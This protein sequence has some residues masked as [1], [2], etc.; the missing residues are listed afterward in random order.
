MH[1]LRPADQPGSDHAKIEGRPVGGEGRD[2]LSGRLPGTEAIIFGNLADSTSA[3]A[4]A[5]TSPRNYALLAEL[6][7][8][9]APTY[10]A[11]LSNPSEEMSQR[12]RLHR[13]RVM[14][15]HD[16]SSGEHDH[17]LPIGPGL[18][19]GSVT[20]K[21]SSLVLVRPYDWR[22]ILGIA[23]GFALTMMLFVAVTYLLL[24]GVG[25]WGINVPVMWGF[26]IVNFVWWIGIGHAGT[27]ISAILLLLKQDWR[28]SINR[29]P[30]H[31]ALRG[32]VCRSLP[33]APSG[34][35]LGLL[36]VAP[37]PQ[38][39]GFMASVAKS[40]DLGR[41][42]GLNLRHGLAPLLVRGTSA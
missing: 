15:T 22:W 17:G 8:R 42:R 21:I 9:S 32:R 10:L 39:D 13:E 1:V 33:P 4:R 16:H 5:K 27:L 3:V 29:L 30:S 6:N 14:T 2:R 18:T 40:F 41:F 19:Y 26:A 35:A 24:K 12:T 31:D 23:V 36:L 34:T 25:I 11:R 28:T 38:H 7:T 20:T 37:L